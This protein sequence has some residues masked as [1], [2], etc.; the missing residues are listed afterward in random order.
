MADYGF[1]GVTEDADGIGGDNGV[2]GGY[3]GRFTPREN[4]VNRVKLTNI[5]SAG[6]SKKEGDY[7]DLAMQQETLSSDAIMAIASTDNNAFPKP[8]LLTVFEDIKPEN[9]TEFKVAPY[10][11]DAFHPEFTWS[12]SDGDL[13]YGFIIIDDIPINNQYHRSVL[14]VPMNEDLKLVASKYD[15]T[16]GW[17]YSAASAAKIYGHRYYNTTKA[18]TG[19]FAGSSLLAGNHTEDY[20]A[21]DSNER[22]TAVEAYIWD[23]VEGLAGNTKH[24]DGTSYLKYSWDA[25]D[26]TNSAFTY[27]VDEMSIVA[28]IT[29]N[30]WAINAQLGGANWAYTDE[31]EIDG[32]SNS[33]ADLKVGMRVTGLGIPEDAYIVSIDDTSTFTLSAATTG[34]P[35]ALQTLTFTTRNYICSLNEANDV[36]LLRD[37]W[38]MYI[39]DEGQINAFIGAAAAATHPTTYIEL[40]STTKVP[41]D[42]TPTNIILTVDTQIHSGNVKLFINGRLED[43]S[44]MR[45]T[46][47]KNNWPTDADGLG[48]DNIFYDTDGDEDLYIGAK[49]ASSAVAQQAFEGKME[50]FTLYD[51]VIYPVIPQN[52]S[53][54][55]DK[56]IEELSVGSSSSSKAYVARLFIKDYHNI[57]GKTT[58][59][60]AAS[61]QVSFKKAAFELNTVVV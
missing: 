9:P 6:S 11:K 13:W 15:N 39:D 49:S 50:E 47:S 30:A 25:E 37:S 42:G 41:I 1:G 18:P 56:P 3:A 32:G 29:P 16:K 19:V 53:F 38:G 46:L 34:G 27:P 7:L 24:F 57:R 54:V 17:Y 22:R 28:H 4:S 43:Q 48:G 2:L 51:K 44:G 26:S 8:F 23:N 20:G 45:G 35:R 36:T 12:A 40:K 60:V 58:E 21:F 31:T 59:E 33:T 61:S 10:E 55:L 5:F 52:G 14:H